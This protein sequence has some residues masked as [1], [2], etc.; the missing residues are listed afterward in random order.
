MESTRLSTS[1]FLRDVLVVAPEL[2]GKTLIRQY[3]DGKIRRFLI[4]ETEAYRGTEDLACHASRGMTG[5][6][7]V[8]FGKGGLV[9]VYFIYGMYWMLNLVTGGEEDASAV[10]I[11]GLDGISGPGKVGR[12]LQLDRTFYGEDLETSQR[13]WIED[14]G[15]IVT[16]SSG[17][18][19]GIHYSGEPWVSMPW[20]YILNKPL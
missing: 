11:R 1:F 5:R 8:M 19:V 12:T 20:R 14:T 2:L 6:N 9:Y 10:L 18:R 7:S 13:L 4:T 17:P 16:Y 15:L 3:S